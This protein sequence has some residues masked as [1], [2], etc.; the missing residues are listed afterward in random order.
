[1][2]ILYG[3]QF[4][5]IRILLWVTKILERSQKKKAS[6]EKEQRF[7]KDEVVTGKKSKEFV[8]VK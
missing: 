6:K 8:K 5:L 1:M 4:C 3:S 7:V 2:I